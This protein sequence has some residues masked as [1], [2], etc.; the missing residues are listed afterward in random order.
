MSG[1]VAE[2]ASTSPRLPQG[3]F[4]PRSDNTKLVD[5]T[6]FRNDLGLFLKMGVNMLFSASQGCIS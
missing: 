2:A 3:C 6:W 1:V 4:M 5:A